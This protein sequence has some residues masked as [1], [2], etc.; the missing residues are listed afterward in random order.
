M[1]EAKKEFETRCV[2]CHGALGEGLI[3]P[4]LTDEYWLHGAAVTDFYKVIDEG[5]PAKGMVPWGP[6]LGSETVMKMAAYVDSLR[7]TNPPNPKE[8][9]GEKVGTGPSAEASGQGAAP[10]SEG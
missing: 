2:V 6:V 8:P 7:G 1:A 9:Q 4:N 3:G 10:E 5:V